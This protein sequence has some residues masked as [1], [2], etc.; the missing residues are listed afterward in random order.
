MKYNIEGLT[1]NARAPDHLTAPRKD[2]AVSSALSANWTINPQNKVSVSVSRQERL[3]NA[4]E[5][6]AHGKH[7]ATNSFDTGNKNLSKEKSSNI[8]FAWAYQGDKFDAQFATYYNHFDNYIY[9]ATLNSG[10]CDWRPDGKCSRSFTDTYPLRLNRYNQSKA[11]IYGLE[12]QFGYQVNDSYH[13]ALFGDY[14]Q[15]KLK[16]LPAL[17]TQI[18]LVFDD[19][20]NIIGTRPTNYKAQPDGN[21]PRIPAARLGLKLNADFEDWYG[22]VQLYRVFDQNRVAHLETPTKG[23]TMLNASLGYDGSVGR[24]GYTLFA[25]AQNLL[26]SRVYNHASFLSYIPQS[27]RSF[28]VGVNVKF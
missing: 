20:D 21:I 13:V 9:L 6:Y 8:E 23:H 1:D 7:V 25:N 11:R 18:E 15:G 24:Y 12:T 3:P 4:Q 2:T 10:N 5:L 26:N 16:D 17:P 22:D 27:G 28:G 19:E 14:V